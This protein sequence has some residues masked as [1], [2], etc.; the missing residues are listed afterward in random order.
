MKI[1]AYEPQQGDALWAILEPAFR[2]GDT[3]TVDRNISRDAGLAFW[4][5]PEKT[6]FMAEAETPVGSYYIKANQGGGGA[7]VCNCGFV[8]NPLARGKGV[9]SAM[10]SHGLK[11]AQAM[12]FLAMQFNFVVAS[13]TGAIR[14]WDR[15]GFDTVGRLPKAFHHP[16]Q[17]YVDALVM[18]KSLKDI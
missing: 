3:Y 5:G 4:T 10:L 14:L 15:A 1:S 9:A 18:Y 11:Q 7:H 2:A 17:G 16:E 12:G 8:T 13:N 6:V